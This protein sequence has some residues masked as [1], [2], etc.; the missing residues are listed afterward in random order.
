MKKTIILKRIFH[1]DQW[2]Y[3]IIFDYDRHLTALVKTIK[4]VKWSQSNKCWYANADEA[5]LRSVFAVFREF[6][7]I[8]IS[9]VSSG[10]KGIVSG[11][12]DVSCF[13]KNAEVISS[14]PVRDK[15]ILNQKVN[16]PVNKDKKI[17]MYAPVVFTISEPDGRLVIKFTGRYDQEWIRELHTFGRPWFDKVTREWFLRWS[18]LAV[19]SLSDYFSSRGVEVIVKKKEIPVVI[20]G[21]RIEQ[22]K[23]VRERTIGKLALEGIDIVRKYLEEKRYSNRTIGSY[24]ACL[25]L[26]FKYFN[27]N[28]PGE[29]SEDDISE[30]IGDHVLKL[31][32]SASY[33]NI[34]IS[35]IK[36]F[37]N[38]NG[39]R[40]VNT[41]ALKRPRR[42]RALPKV[43]SKEEIM[44]IFS[45]T[46]NNKHKLILWLIYS[47]GLRRSEVINIKLTDLDRERGILNIREAKG[48]TNRMVPIPQKVWE[49]IG[50]YINSYKPVTYLFEGQTG[51][52]Y[53]AESVYAVFK[54]SLKF[55]GIK[56]DVGVHSLRHSYA[57][58][59]HEGGLDI[60]YIQELLG[61]KS[62]R[63]T[64][65]YT[66]VSRRNLFAIRSPIED[67]E[68]D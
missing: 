11:T 3:S 6:A 17:S 63:T 9:D 13:D 25:E 30:F 37:Y 16:P 62:S 60:R 38:L 1:R 54:R 43:F 42:S 29:I 33:Q 22:G 12:T 50:K 48:N 56:K 34:I 44:E 46:K 18:Q 53:S 20:A 35:A 19:D 15:N 65:I 40:I 14:L 41:D 4:G 2:R 47:C 23:E 26:F 64:E 58:H 28:D 61:H 36:M 32:Y 59:L 10:E 31:G 67:M 7:D 49:K 66:H 52:K 55:A 5:T 68:L 57:T 24:V 21:I 45:A 8:D 51:G 27:N 39:K